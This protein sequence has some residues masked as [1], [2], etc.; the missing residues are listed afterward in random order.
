MIAVLPKHKYLFPPVESADPDGLLAIGG[1]LTPERI[2]TAYRHGIFPWYC[3]NSEI[4]WLGNKILWWSPDPRFVLYPSKIHISKSMKRILQQKRFNITINK[5][6]PAVIS[7]CRHEVRV[8]QEG[9]WIT[10]N[11]EKAYNELH[12]LGYA[13]SVEAWTEN[14]LAG[15]LY[16]ILMGKAFFGES[17]FALFTNASKAAFITFVKVLEKAGCPLIDCQ[18]ETEHLKTLGAELIPRKK[19]IKTISKAVKMPSIDFNKI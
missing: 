17:M 12:K 3:E 19:F 14:T 4:D 13:I 1:D 15:G 6:F 9:T 5:A 18:V 7:R 8:R 10:E 11:M 16:G 2:L